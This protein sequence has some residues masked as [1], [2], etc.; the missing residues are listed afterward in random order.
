MPEPAIGEPV[1]V[2]PRKPDRESRIAHHR[3]RKQVVGEEHRGVDVQLIELLAHRS[4]NVTICGRFEPP[5]Q[6]MR[7]SARG[8][9]A[10]RSR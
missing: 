7:N 4:G 9:I 3:Q 10:G 1:V 2:R 8:E 6:G 5:G